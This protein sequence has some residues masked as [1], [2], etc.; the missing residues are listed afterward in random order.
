MQ[1]FLPFHWTRAHHVTCKKV[2]KNNGLLMRNVVQLCLTANNILPMRKWH[3]AFLLFA[4]AWQVA[5]L[6][7]DIP[8]NKTR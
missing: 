6:P 3:H 1:I 7:E 5:S 8:L 4:I 2:P